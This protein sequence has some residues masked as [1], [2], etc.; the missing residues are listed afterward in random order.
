M[1]PLSSKKRRDGVATFKLPS[2]SPELITPVHRNSKMGLAAA[3]SDLIA[4]PIRFLDF[5]LSTRQA[6]ANS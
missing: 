5:Q 2:G 1:Q 6:R 4:L 3:T